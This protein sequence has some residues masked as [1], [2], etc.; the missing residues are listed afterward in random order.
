MTKLY[1][2]DFFAWTQDQADALRRRSVNEIDW[3]NLL[4]EVESLGR[5]QQSELTSHMAVLLTHLLKWRM[6]PAR[7]S[8]SWVLTILEQRAQA[9]RLMRDNPS[10]KPRLDE[11]LSDAYKLAR[12][13]AA[14]ETRLSLGNIPEASPFDWTDAMTAPIAL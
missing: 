11:V 12:L 1:D 6:Q 7:R 8:R 3:D 10:L 4:E 14:R 5:Q 9:E 2:R 13:R